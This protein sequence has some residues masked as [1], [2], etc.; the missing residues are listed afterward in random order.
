MYQV[1]ITTNDDKSNN[2]NVIIK[3]KEYEWLLNNQYA[4]DYL[5]YKI[6]LYSDN[7]P[8]QESEFEKIMVFF[9]ENYI[10]RS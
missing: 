6:S 4:N 10:F 5:L 9:K 1:I 7:V 2:L 8:H 3:K